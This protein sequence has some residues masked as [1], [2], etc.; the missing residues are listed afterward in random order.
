MIK[1]QIPA[2]SANLGAGFDALGL[3]VDL[4][5]YVTVGESDRLEIVTSDDTVVPTDESNLVYRSARYLFE[6]CGKKLNGLKIIQQNN[7]P[8][9]RGLGSSSAC[10]IAG[11]YGANILLGSPFNTDELVNIAA[12]LEG[13]PDNT[14]PA[15]LGGIVTAAYDNSRVYWTKQEIY[16]HLDFFAVV[17][18]FELSTAMARKCLP[19][20]VAHVD[21]RF[22]LSRAALFSASLL[23]GKYENIRV[24][25][26][27]RLHQPFRMGL[28][29]HADEI[30]KKS[31]ELGAYG[32]YV[33]GAGPTIMSIVSTENRG[34]EK[35]IRRY[36]DSLELQSWKI[37]RLSIDNLGTRVVL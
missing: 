32:T 28:I 34:Y 35:E 31:Y 25:V 23:Q 17:P 20:T 2:T 22:N 36:L 19:E 9:T 11:L 26:N 14:T 37:Y 10:I 6:K 7:I 1:I 12:K 4:Y 24:A 27:D 8:M 13:H 15:L 30:F 21:A 5:N 16:R 18:D 29:V 33:S 3:A